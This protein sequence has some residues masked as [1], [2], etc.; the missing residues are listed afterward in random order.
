MGVELL[1]T[2]QSSETCVSMPNEI[3]SLVRTNPK[4]VR[5][6]IIRKTCVEED[7][8][9]GNMFVQV[10][11]NVAPSL[12]ELISLIIL[13]ESI[14]DCGDLLRSSHHLMED[15][16]G[17]HEFQF[18]GA[19]NRALAECDSDGWTIIQSRGQFDNRN[20]YFYR[21][22]DSY[23]DGFGVPG[24]EYWLGLDNIF[25]LARQKNYELRVTLT[26]ADGKEGVGIWHSF[27][28]DNRARTIERTFA[29]SIC[30]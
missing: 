23:V 15:T 18:D 16:A 3:C 13:P 24:A 6:P 20:A 7:Q 14:Q 25:F 17:I 26:D 8:V 1:P 27:K 21:R 2:L 28:L 10:A 30:P 4:T 11:I 19:P 22:W 12:T 29:E 5:T 9:E